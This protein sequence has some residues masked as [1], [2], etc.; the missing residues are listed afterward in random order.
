MD[1][2]GIETIASCTIVDSYTINGA[3]AATPFAYS[4]GTITVTPT[5][6][7]QVMAYTVVFT[8]TTADPLTLATITFVVNVLP[9]DC[10]KILWVNPPLFVSTW[11]GS[12]LSTQAGLEDTQVTGGTATVAQCVPV[13]VFSVQ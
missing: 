10:S 5:T 8:H 6:L 9:M 1:S 13:T 3:A 7:A 11:V 4:A 12:G 2:G